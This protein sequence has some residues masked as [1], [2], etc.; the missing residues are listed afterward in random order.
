M[1]NV[2]PIQVQ[3]Y[4]E[5]VNYPASKDDLVKKAKDEGAS[6]DVI[7]TLQK[8]PGQQYDSPVDVSQAIGKIE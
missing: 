5:G 6:E 4:L 7:Q 8:M 2:N 3:K 1:A